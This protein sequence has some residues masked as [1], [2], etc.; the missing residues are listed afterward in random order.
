MSRHLV[1]SL[2]RMPL[3]SAAT[4]L[5]IGCAAADASTDNIEQLRYLL[6][7]TGTT[8]D[9]PALA[10]EPTV[11]P[12]GDVQQRA[13]E[14]ILAIN[15]SYPPPAVPA[16][17]EARLRHASSAKG[18]LAHDDAQALARRLLV[19]PASAATGS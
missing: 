14:L 17:G 10:P 13:R 12:M 11:K 15:K 6:A 9:A 4:I 18:L 5:S 7:G 16:T 8:H 3:L 19:V 2:I 1:V